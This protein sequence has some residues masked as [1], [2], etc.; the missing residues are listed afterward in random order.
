M[1]I[2]QIDPI[3]TAKIAGPKDT[4]RIT[5]T[6]ADDYNLFHDKMY[7]ILSQVNACEKLL[8]YTTDQKDKNI[9]ESEIS[10]LKTILDLI[11]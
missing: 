6:F 2:N 11:S 3:A 10:E 7:I 1:N 8:K 4:K 5:Y 9:L